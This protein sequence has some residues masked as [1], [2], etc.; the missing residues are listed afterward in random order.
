MRPWSTHDLHSV[1]HNVEIQGSKAYHS[2]SASFFQRKD[3]PQRKV[4]SKHSSA[5]L[6]GSFRHSF[7]RIFAMTLSFLHITKANL[8]RVNVFLSICLA[9][10]CLRR[11]SLVRA[12]M[13]P[14]G[15]FVTL[16]LRRN[17][18]LVKSC[19]STQSHHVLRIRPTLYSQQGL[20]YL[21]RQSAIMNGDNYSSRGMQPASIKSKQQSGAITDS[22]ESADA[23][24]HSS[25]REPYVS[26]HSISS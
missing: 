21:S 10:L 8:R 3:C 4:V 23:G 14:G 2:S 26:N 1:I 19:R 18:D 25:F 7:I 20:T 22:R 13:E 11:Q 15:S 5:R 24:R 17:Y 9:Y 16:N 6:I 12:L